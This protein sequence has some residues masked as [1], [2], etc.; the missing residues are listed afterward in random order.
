MYIKYGNK[1]NKLVSCCTEG[2]CYPIVDYFTDSLDNNTMISDEDLDFINSTL[3]KYATPHSII[4]ATEL[5]GFLTAIVSGPDMIMPSEWLPAIW[6]G[7]EHTPAWDSEKEVTRF[8]G[9]AITMM[10]ETAD[11]LM[12]EPDA[13]ET[14]FLKDSNKGEPVTIAS[15]W[16]LGYMRA[17]NIRPESWA[18]LPEEMQQELDHIALFSGEGADILSEPSKAD[19][20]KLQ[21]KVEPAARALHVFWL[22]QRAHLAPPGGFPAHAR[23]QAQIL[24][25][26]RSQPK[27]GPNQPCPCGSGKKYKKCCGAP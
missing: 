1:N 6:G 25:F 8:M 2:G 16:G 27:I 17:V 20:K 11:L 26:V 13:F 12:E 14:M 24:P 23:P 15:F 18:D 10:N 19:I 5:D 7:E 9:L 21:D 22:E 3:D 4:N